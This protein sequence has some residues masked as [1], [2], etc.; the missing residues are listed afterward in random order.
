ML[1]REHIQGMN[2]AELR[3]QVL[4]P[5]LRA[6]GYQD[7]TEYHGGAGEQGKDIV[8]WLPDKLGGRTNLALVVK[9][10]PLSG[11]AAISRG[12]AGEVQ[13]QIRQC[14]GDDFIDPVTGERE[15]IHECWVVSSQRITKE[16]EVAIMSA[17]GD[18]LARSVRFVGGDKLWE[19]VEEYLG[20]R[21]VLGRL[22]E[23][24]RLLGT[25][26][27]HIHPE[28]HLLPS[29]MQITL[30][31]KDPAAPGGRGGTL[32]VSPPDTPAGRVAREA[33]ERFVTTGETVKLP[34]DF[35][36]F[37]GMPDILRRLMGDDRRPDAVGLASVAPATPSVPVRIELVGE[38]SDPVTLD[39]ID[40]R[41]IQVGTEEITLSNRQ[42]AVPTEVTVVLRPK[43]GRARVS[44]N[45]RRPSLNAHQVN[46]ALRLRRCFSAPYVA[47]VIDL[48]TGITLLEAR[49]TE[50]TP[51]STPLP[52]L[53]EE[54]GDLAIIQRRT[55]VPIVMPERDLTDEEAGTIGTLRRILREGWAAGTWREFEFDCTA[56]EARDLLDARGDEPQDFVVADE[57]TADLFGAT[58]PLGPARIT[59]HDARL[60][61]EADISA[62]LLAG[63][64]DDIAVRLVPDDEGTFVAEY[65]DW[66]PRLRGVAAI[67]TNE[68]IEAVR[69]L[70]KAR[71]ELRRVLADPY[72][73][74]WVIIALHNALQGF[75]VLA[76]QGTNPAPIAR[77]NKTLLE[78]YNLL[79]PVKDLP[80]KV[81]EKYIAE[82]YGA[83]LEPQAL[84]E[85]LERPVTSL[86]DY[87]LVNFMDLFARI[88]S[89]DY[90]R[91]ARAGAFQPTLVQVEDVASLNEHRNLFTHFTPKTLI[92]H[93][94][95]L[96]FPRLVGT[97]LTVIEFLLGSDNIVWRSEEGLEQQAFRLV[98]EAWAETSRIASAYSLVRE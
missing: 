5:L 95:A 64:T 74:K 42:Q 37:S 78:A 83:N 3:Q 10:T 76:T 73:W 58:I 53:I 39:Y 61:N 24:R 4:L 80:D 27:P 68:R 31:A 47:R 75:M 45:Y 70:D 59:I 20:A 60:A 30:A 43:A 89:D 55:K 35:V 34:G 9:A 81:R 57:Q 62:A 71:E 1:T 98:Q 65:L 52:A 11:K 38:A 96:D 51:L 92:V 44:V 87:D 40:L 15:P 21:T 22:E 18:P 6:M 93:A 28:V 13:M 19:R 84:Q 33:F 17:L 25:L 69:A 23:A 77:V 72:Y 49:H 26:D 54:V 66:Q 63:E 46:F 82:N 56:D 88:Q 32:A 12:S 97:C 79:R 94:D 36:E 50:G 90:M 85:I 67:E 8:G 91:Q 7:V 86:G 48:A 14:F 41:A 2:E 29:G 16:A